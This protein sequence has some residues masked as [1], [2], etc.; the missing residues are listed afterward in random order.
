MWFMQ[1]VW[2][3]D[4]SSSE[5]NAEKLARWLHGFAEVEHSVEPWCTA[6]SLTDRQPV[7]SWKEMI[8]GAKTPAGGPGAFSVWAPCGDGNGY[9]LTFH[10]GIASQRFPNQL[11]LQIPESRYESMLSST[12]VER[13]LASAAS[14]W[15]V[16]FAKASDSALARI[17]PRRNGFSPGWVT[18]L[19]QSSPHIREM[20]YMGWRSADLG[21]IGRLYVATEAYEEAGS[22]IVSGWGGG[23]RK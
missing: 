11:M 16:R 13:L 2:Y 5:L 10:C 3:E 22:V 12:V 1:A 19:P 18:L 17:V 15:K 6:T 7:R 21:D 23:D 9:N 20:D 8:D 14:L 4:A